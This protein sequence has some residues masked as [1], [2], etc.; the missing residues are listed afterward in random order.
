MAVES[1][2]ALYPTSIP[3][4]ADSADIQ[5]ALR[6]YHYGSYEYDT[7]NT[8]PANLVSPS[9]AHTLNSLQDSIDNIDLSAAI[10]KTDLN[11]KGDILSASANDTLSVLSVGSNGR[12][13]T[14]NSTTT[15]GL[16]WSDTLTALS[17]SAPLLTLDTTASTTDARIAWDTTN[18]KIVVGNGSAALDI[19]PFVVNATAKS[20]AYTLALGDQSTLIQ[21][22]GAQ[23]ITVPLNATVAYPVGAI[24]HLLSISGQPVVS[25]TA[26]ITS[27]YSPG[28]KLRATGSMASLVKLGTNT[29]A[30]TGDLVA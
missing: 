30:L 17:L 11:A 12:V 27:Y 1:I 21:V 9:V 13:L 23:T 6:A 22:S 7:T 2:G 19:A 10:Q 18:K 15:T 24:I 25:F 4:Y 5:A 3:G 28:L 20:A 16:E 8:D 26:G 14:A 29:W